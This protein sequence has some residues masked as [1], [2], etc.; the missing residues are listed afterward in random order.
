MEYLRKTL[1]TLLQRRSQLIGGL[2][3]GS[4]LLGSN[5][6]F[7]HDHVDVSVGLGVAA[8]P[9]VYQQP[10][11]VYAQPP[12]IVEQPRVVG[13]RHHDEW[14]RKRAWREHEWREHEWREHERREHERREHAWREHYWHDR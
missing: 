3:M 4:A 5:A 10:P 1:L 8:P 6:A 13:W 9:V 12:V 2:L 7:A 14:R 11:V